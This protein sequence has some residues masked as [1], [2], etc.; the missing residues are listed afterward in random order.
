MENGERGVD[1]R[2][3]ADQG[4]H[5]VPER[6]GVLRVQAA[7]AKLV[8]DV[9]GVQD[10]HL[11]EL[12]DPSQMEEGIA[13]DDGRRP[14]DDAAEHEAAHGNGSSRIEI[15]P[16]ERRGCRPKRSQR[17]TGRD[18]AEHDDGQRQRAARRERERER[19][20]DGDETPGKRAGDHLP[21]PSRPVERTQQECSGK[22]QDAR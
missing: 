15:A 7:V 4:E 6:K 16:I 12:S 18:D 10:G 21:E 2:E 20:R 13:V 3:S 19:D 22:K 1:S 8:D 5:A 9:N 14:P 11:V 17:A